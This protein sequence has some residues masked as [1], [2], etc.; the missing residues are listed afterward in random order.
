MGTGRLDNKETFYSLTCETEEIKSTYTTLIP[1]LLVNMHFCSPVSVLQ[2]CS[3]HPFTIFWIHEVILQALRG[4]QFTSV[5]VWAK[6]QMP[7]GF[8]SQM[9]CCQPELPEPNG[10]VGCRLL[11]VSITFMPPTCHR[12]N[13]MISQDLIM[14][15]VEQT[16]KL[17][18]TKARDTWMYPGT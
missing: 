6:K 7:E 14:I 11:H 18:C 4:P 1:F 12:Q 13:L 5:P 9:N 2:P 8:G 10:G 16:C 15:W 17:F 3:L